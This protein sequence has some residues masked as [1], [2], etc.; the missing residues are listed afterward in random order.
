MM[1]PRSIFLMD[2]AGM[3]EDGTYFHRGTLSRFLMF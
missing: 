3:H 1:L 2:L